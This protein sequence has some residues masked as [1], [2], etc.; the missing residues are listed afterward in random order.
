MEPDDLH[1]PCL[2]AVT[3]APFQLRFRHHLRLRIYIV[4]DLHAK[5]GPG[6]APTTYPDLDPAPTL[7]PVPDPNSNKKKQD[8]AEW[9]KDSVKEN[10]KPVTTAFGRFPE[11]RKTY[12]DKS[13]SCKYIFRKPTKK[14]GGSWKFSKFLMCF[15]C[16]RNMWSAS[17]WGRICDLIL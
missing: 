6:R 11:P 7:D 14:P 1:D 2:S 9:F 10:S 3:P 13:V 4:P 8:Y 12:L 5:P 15:G 17:A 16:Y